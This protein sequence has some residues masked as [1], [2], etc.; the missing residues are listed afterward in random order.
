[1]HRVARAR[2]LA[3]LRAAIGRIAPVPATRSR[4]CLARP[5][6]AVAASPVRGERGV[7]GCMSI[8]GMPSRAR[9][10]NGA[11]RQRASRALERYAHRFSAHLTAPGV[12][13]H[14]CHVQ[15]VRSRR[16]RGRP[17]RDLPVRELGG[18]DARARLLRR[19]RLGH[20]GARD[21]AC[22][23]CAASS[24]AAAAHPRIRLRH[25]AAGWPSSSA[26]AIA[27]S[28]S[29]TAPGRCA[30]PAPH[31]PG[32]AA[33]ARRR[34]CDRRSRPPAS[35]PSSRPTSPSTSR[36]ARSGL[37]REIHRAAGPAAC[38]C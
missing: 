23:P 17:R 21:R 27:P 14:R 7:R 32:A 35:T 18:A 4:C 29:T 34:R 19:A 10:R 25:A 8:R 24:P 26:S 13:A 37:L 6:A 16:D 33:G 38:C 5:R 22:R 12:P 3:A 11:S 36:T 15:A 9:P 1:M 28:A 20:R 30:S 2:R 31:D